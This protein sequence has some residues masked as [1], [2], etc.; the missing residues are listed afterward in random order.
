MEYGGRL[1]LVVWLLS[2]SFLSGCLHAGP[3]QVVSNRLSYLDESTPPVNSHQAADVQVALGKSFEKRGDLDRARTAY[4]EAIKRDPNRADAYARLAVIDDRLGRFKESGQNF[5]KSLQL[6]P[7]DPDVYCDLGYSLYLQRRWAE[8]E[9]ALH[10]ALAVKQD[11]QR[12]H[13]NLGLLL[14][15]TERSAQALD[16]FQAAGSDPAGAHV[17]L[18]IAMMVDARWDQAR[19]EYQ[20][21]LAADPGCMAARNGLQDLDRLVAHARPGY[22]SGTLGS[23]SASLA[24]PLGTGTDT[25]LA[26]TFFRVGE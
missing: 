26:R 22:V 11:H 1:S 15:R 5:R 25:Q 6:N 9:T 7:A 23:T 12:A 17:N 10:Q 20:N 18:A 14:A 8:S 3:G 19:Q 4:E 13:N 16:Q 2:A 21:A 24:Q